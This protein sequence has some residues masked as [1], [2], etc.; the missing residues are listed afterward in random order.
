MD[1]NESA[2]S[3]R[4]SKGEQ[5]V[6]LEETEYHRTL[7]WQGSLSFIELQEHDVAPS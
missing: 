3:F 2:G 7:R 6:S 1:Q 4:N 5:Q